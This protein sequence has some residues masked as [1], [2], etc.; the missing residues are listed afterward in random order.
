LRRP[1]VLIRRIRRHL[2]TTITRHSH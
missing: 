1:D 2:G